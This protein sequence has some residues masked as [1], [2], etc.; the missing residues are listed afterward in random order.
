MSEDNSTYTGTLKAAGGYDAPW[1][2][3]RA[4][5]PQGFSDALENARSTLLQEL[6][7]TADL[8]A[9]AYSVVKGLNAPE[10]T[11]AVANSQQ[12]AQN[13]PQAGT[14]SFCP[15]GQR[16]LRSNKPG[17]QKEWSA[18]FCPSKDKNNQCKP[19]DAKTGTPWN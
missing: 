14:G 18:Y 2:V 19:I 4:D 13:A 15:H 6:S 17:A 8:F 3:V 7:E 16:D 1:L 5:T 10:T 11:A 12:A 9:T